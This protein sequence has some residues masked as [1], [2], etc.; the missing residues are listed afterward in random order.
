MGAATGEERADEREIYCLLGCW[1]RLGSCREEWTEK[2]THVPHSGGYLG[3]WAQK[4]G[5][6]QIGDGRLGGHFQPSLVRVSVELGQQELEL[7][8]PC[9]RPAEAKDLGGLPE[10]PEYVL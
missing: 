2:S 4:V 7:Q 3:S 9:K 1:F 5:G 6:E 8:I 10:G